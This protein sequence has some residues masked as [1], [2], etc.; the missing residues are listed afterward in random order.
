MENQENI[1]NLNTGR[2][3]HRKVYNWLFVGLMSL[4]VLFL[5]FYLTMNVMATKQWISGFNLKHETTKADKKH[6]DASLFRDSAFV[7]LQREISFIKARTALT[8]AEPIAL[9]VNITDSTATLVIKGVTVHKSAITEINISHTLFA[10]EPYWLAAELSSPLQIKHSRATIEKEPIIV[11]NAPNDTTEVENTGNLPDTSNTTPVFFELTFHNGFRLIVLEEDSDEA[12]YRR[13]YRRFFY[14]PALASARRNVISI[15]KFKIP[16]YTPEIRISM[17][18]D[19]AR[20][21]YRAIPEEG[22]VALRLN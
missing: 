7:S 16:E 9:I 18:G 4:I 1:A 11:K 22:F 17:P 2:R 21:I 6:A 20:A 8:S 14:G 15:L 19:E 13:A 5:I 10:V 12:I 3:N